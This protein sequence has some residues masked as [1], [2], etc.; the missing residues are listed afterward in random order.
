MKCKN[1]IRKRRYPALFWL[2]KLLKAMFTH[3]KK[4]ETP[5]D[6][7]ERQR[8]RREFTDYVQKQAEATEQQVA[9]QL[10]AYAEQL[11]TLS[12]NELARYHISA[13]PFVHHVE[14]L[15][16]QIPGTIASEV[17][18]RMTDSDAV[19]QKLCRMMPGAEKEKATQE[20]MREIIGQGVEKCSRLAQRVLDQLEEDL[21][22]A[23]Q[24]KLEQ[25]QQQLERTQQ[26]LSALAEAAGDG[27][28]QEKLKAQAE[29]LCAACDLTE[30]LFDRDEG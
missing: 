3:P 14:L 13:V 28:Q 22:A 9:A 27:Q 26:E 1:D 5:Q 19:Y 29:L 30:E 7:A 16:M 20:F 24:E 8:W 17:S 25:S 4:K 23:L 2:I 21:T 15:S 12:Q 10:R 18:R 6:V 11:L